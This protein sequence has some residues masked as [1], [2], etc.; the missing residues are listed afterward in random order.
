MKHKFSLRLCPLGR[1]SSHHPPGLPASSLLICDL[2]PWGPH[3]CE[4]I[5]YISLCGS[6]HTEWYTPVPRRLLQWT[7]FPF[8][9]MC[10][11]VLCLHSL[12]PLHFLMSVHC[13]HLGLLYYLPTVGRAAITRALASCLYGECLKLEL[14]DCNWPFWEKKKTFTCWIWRGEY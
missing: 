13:D 12:Y 10:S 14:L 9:I 5:C 3:I 8:G 7:R 2:P 1:L 6:S 11:I 4:N